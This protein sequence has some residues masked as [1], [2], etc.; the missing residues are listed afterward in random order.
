MINSLMVRLY[1]DYPLGNQLLDGGYFHLPL[2]YLTDISRFLC[3]YSAPDIIY[4]LL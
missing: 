4:N 3:R 2:R 1:I